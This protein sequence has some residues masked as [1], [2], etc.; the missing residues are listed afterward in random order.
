MISKKR[1]PPESDNLDEICDEENDGV[2]DYPS[3]RK[4]I[5]KLT[6]EGMALQ[7]T[8][9]S[10]KGRNCFSN[11]ELQ[12]INSSYDECKKRL[13]RSNRLLHRK[14]AYTGELRALEK[15]LEDRNTSLSSLTPSMRGSL[16]VGI[17]E[18]LLGG[19]ASAIK[20]IQEIHAMIDET[21]ENGGI[22][23]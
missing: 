12:H 9:Q 18:K 20:R 16:N 11:E 21:S 14:R 13:E 19:H 7:E 1:A 6:I 15:M 3:L 17:F 23:Y 10:M 4:R 2:T 22:I 8:L 5:E